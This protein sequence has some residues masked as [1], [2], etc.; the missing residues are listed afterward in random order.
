MRLLHQVRYHGF[1]TVEG[2]YCLHYQIIEEKLNGVDITLYED[3]QNKRV[4]QI[5]F[6]N[7]Q[8]R[9]DSLEPLS[10][11][12]RPLNET[13]IDMDFLLQARSVSPALSI[14]SHLLTFHL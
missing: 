13:D 9:F 10:E 11:G 12:D 14:S 2:V 7:F 1:K 8:W 6:A 4:W 5:E 3:H